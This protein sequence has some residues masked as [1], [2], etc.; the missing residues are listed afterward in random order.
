MKL[1]EYACRVGVNDKTAGRWWRAGKL[2]AY[3]AAS[4]TVIV[5]E[6]AETAPPSP[7][8]HH[9]A[10]YARV[11]T[12]EH[13]PHLESQAERLSTSCA[14]K[15]EQGSRGSKRSAPASTRAAPNS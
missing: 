3:Q 9:V 7:A 12:A 15:G 6:P 1:S 4:G 14:A 11:S 10:I 2:D 8:H 5:R 13:R